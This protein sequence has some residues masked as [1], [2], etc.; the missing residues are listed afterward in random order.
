MITTE[1]FY[2]FDVG[3]ANYLARQQ[4]RIG[5]P[6]FGKAFE[7]YILMELKAFQAYRNPEMPVTFWRTSTGREVDFIL[8]D[9]DLAIEIKASSRIHESDIRSLQALLEDGPVKKCC[10]VSLEKQ[11]RQLTKNIEA[12]PWQ[13]FVERLWRDEF[14]LLP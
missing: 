13:Q 4:P 1:K 2:L 5:S 14:K 3:V 6:T 11:K 12:I 9:K 8:G 10:V 7:H